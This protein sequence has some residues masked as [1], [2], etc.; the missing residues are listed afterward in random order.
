MDRN[1]IVRIAIPLSLYESVKGKV[2]SESIHE[3]DD[4]SKYEWLTDNLQEA[5]YEFISEGD[6]RQGDEEQLKS[7]VDSAI[8]RLVD[9]YIK[10]KL[11]PAD[12]NEA[13]KPADAPQKKAADKNRV[14]IVT[15]EA[16]TGKHVVKRVPRNASGV[17]KKY[18][19]REEAQKY[20]DDHNKK[21]AKVNEGVKDYYQPNPVEDDNTKYDKSVYSLKQSED[22]KFSGI[23]PLIYFDTESESQANQMAD[24]YTNGQF[25]KYP[26]FYE[27][28]KIVLPFYKK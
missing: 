5:L 25:T 21:D 16:G 7:D 3:N 18:D 19:T 23:D 12:I 4:Y 8:S 9:Q 22:G 24:E 26:G 1:T 13:K 11:K 6:Y 2:L 27:L 28:K 17:G 10:R 14:Y 20:A 15:S